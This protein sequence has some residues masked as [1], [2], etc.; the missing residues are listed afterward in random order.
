VPAHIHCPQC[1]TAFAYSPALLGKSVRC[2]QCQHTFVV[3][4]PSDEAAASATASAGQVLVPPPLPTRGRGA[5]TNPRPRDDEFIDERPRSRT[6][7]DGPRV[8]REP[9]RS[10]RPRAASPEGRSSG[11]GTLV[12]LIAVC[13]LGL[14]VLAGGIGY[15]LWPSSA[16][17]TAPAGDVPA[18]PVAAPVVVDTPK[19]LDEILK[20]APSRPGEPP[21]RVQPKKFDPAARPGLPVPRQPM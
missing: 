19:T 14:V 11:A 4:G 7:D 16:T 1:S 2:R 5:Q 13:G 6:R 3:S 10:R 17:T 18:A 12:A 15:L 20:D 21:G 9:E 8:R